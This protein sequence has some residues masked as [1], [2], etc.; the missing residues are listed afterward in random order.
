MIVHDALTRLNVNAV[1]R[2]FEPMSEADYLANVEIAGARPPWAAV[3]AAALAIARERAIAAVQGVADA[4]HRGT[5][6]SSP[7]QHAR[8]LSKAE[9]AHLMQ[10]AVP[11]T[12]ERLAPEA[13]ARGLS[14]EAFAALVRAK[15][16]ASKVMIAQIEAARAAAGNR[17]AAATTREEVA[18]AAREATQLIN[19]LGA[20]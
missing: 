10:L 8:H 14:V 6:A 1:I 2:D 7:E 18:E 5:G 15:R 9:D 13:E 17:I 4:K 19:A 12:A 16:E 3:Q 11:G 20:T